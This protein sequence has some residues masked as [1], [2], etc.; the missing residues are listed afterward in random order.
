M[1]SE[2][3]IRDSSTGGDVFTFVMRMEGVEFGEALR[4]LG[5]KAGVQIEK[6][7][8]VSQ[9]DV[10]YRINQE[11]AR[12][13]EDVLSSNLG[14]AAREYLVERGV[15]SEITSKFQLGF[16][17]TGWVG[18]R[19]YLLGLGFQE[20]DAIRAGVLRKGNRGQSRDFFSGRLMFPIWDRR[21][22]VV[23]FGGRSLDGSEPKYINLSLIHI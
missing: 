23:G 2:M 8:S 17:P 14:I 3:C 9:D 12:F 16:S 4:I 7:G 19:G 20:D 1:G 21:G 5:Q 22:R 11:T 10:L 13:Y 6:S 18:L 15:G